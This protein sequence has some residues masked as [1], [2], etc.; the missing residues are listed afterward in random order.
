MGEARMTEQI[1]GHYRAPFSNATPTKLEF[2]DGLTLAEMVALGQIDI[3]W[4]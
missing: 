4:T 3:S 2:A 1:V